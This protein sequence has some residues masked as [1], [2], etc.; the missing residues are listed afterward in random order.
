MGKIEILVGLSFASYLLGALVC[1]IPTLA[2]PWRWRFAHTSSLSALLF[3]IAAIAAMALGE[4]ATANPQDVLSMV[5]HPDALGLGTLLLVSFLAVVIV[6]FSRTYLDGE[7]HQ[8]RY[9][10]ALMVTLAAVCVIVITDNLGVLVAAWTVTS[11][12]LHQLLTFY[13]SRTEAII[14]AHK[15][16]IASR[17]AEVFLV[18]AVVILYLELGTVSIRAID[19][20][21]GSVGSPSFLVQLATALF[22]FGVILKT[23]QLP[24]H[25]WLIQVMEA[26]T[27]VS[28]LLHAG[29]VNLSGFVL[30]RLAELISAAPGAQ[31]L[32][33]LVGSLTAVLAGL[34]MLT[35]IS[36][37][38]R[39][40]W[41]TCAQMGFMLMEC[42]LGLY[43]LAFVHLLGHSL[44]KAH[45]F[46]SSGSAVRDTLVKRLAP[47]DRVPGGVWRWLWP[48]LAVVLAGAM[49][50]VLSR[51][52]GQIIPHAA[53]PLAWS[54][55]LGLA[56]APVLWISGNTLGVYGIARSLFTLALIGLLYMAWHALLAYTGL[57]HNT[58]APSW[59]LAWSALSL[60]VLYAAQV[61][62]HDEPEAPWAIALYR[63]AYAGFYLD[64][65]AT[66][67]TFRIWPAR[68]AASNRN[69]ALTLPHT[70][71]DPR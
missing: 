1:A 4:R 21:V 29:V 18:S 26:P 28:A 30:I 22:A 10:S 63:W 55:V 45:A 47:V 58:P 43:E 16:F 33:V 70:F 8:Q 2:V 42:G 25:G 44:Y 65:W 12:G 34:V 57:A 17:F 66:R 31:I 71:G 64:E 51:V 48:V 38:V 15:K 24:V 23:A 54:V 69:D 62:L 14:A 50:D 37:K 41:S 19:A 49:M 67:M 40:A 13:E 60:A 68:I 6:R 53:L 61:M 20:Y 36:I 9:V 56:F 11:L 3:C 32:L 35:R 7:A 59:L 46:L 27:P 5:L 52:L 39:L